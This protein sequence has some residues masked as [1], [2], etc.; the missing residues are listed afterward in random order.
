MIH[1]RKGMGLNKGMGYKNLIP[2]YDSH[3]HALNAKGYKMPQ[4]LPIG[5]LITSRFT[6]AK[7][8]VVS[9][10]PF[11][12]KY[13]IGDKKAVR[14]SNPK[15]WEKG[16]KCN[17]AFDDV[18]GYGVHCVK[19][20]Y[21]PAHLISNPY[22]L[23]TVTYRGKIY[24][25]D[26]K[27]GE[28]RNVATAEP[29]KFTNLGGDAK[30]R[31]HSELRGLR[32]RYWANEYIAGVDDVKGEM[33]KGGKKQYDKLIEQYRYTYSE[34]NKRK[35][36]IQNL[37]ESDK[38]KFWQYWGLY[39]IGVTTAIEAV[40]GNRLALALV[41]NSIKEHPDWAK[42]GKAPL[43]KLKELS[44]TDTLPFDRK[45]M[46]ITHYPIETSVI[47]PSTQ[48]VDKKLSKAKFNQRVRQSKKEL[49]KLLDGYTKVDTIGGFY[50][51]DSKKIV[52]EKGAKITIFANRAK[53]SQKSDQYKQWILRKQKE[54]GQSSIGFETEGDLYY[55][56]KK[57]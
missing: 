39:G 24:F 31:I 51:K 14:L 20:G 15:F 21:K 1:M 19:C 47:I 48:D 40:K 3:R 41:E 12:V 18:V 45:G 55:L 7:G 29:I 56:S 17:H 30:D 9:T 22:K 10:S 11:A 28:L 46:K 4:R 53:L 34:I 13:N 54:W 57:K 37:S 52:E 26:F 27:L 43:E 36:E 2:S 33:Q 35:N 42:G 25:V 16:G 5:A 44:D 50:D 23:P 38:Q 49:G 6:K 32:S 8:Q